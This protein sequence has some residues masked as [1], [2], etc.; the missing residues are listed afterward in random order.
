[1]TDFHRQQE[2]KLTDAAG[3]KHSHYFSEKVS[4]DYLPGESGSQGQPGVGTEVLHHSKQEG[5]SEITTTNTPLS[6]EPQHYTEAAKLIDQCH[7]DARREAEEFA[8]RQQQEQQ[9]L[10]EKE[11]ELSKL[12]SEAQ[13]RVAELE[14][15]VEK[16]RK[17]ELKD[18]RKLEEQENK[19]MKLAQ[20]LANKQQLARE[21]EEAKRNLAQMRQIQASQLAEQIAAKKERLRA[22]AE[23]RANQLAAEEEAAKIRAAE[24]A[25]HQAQNVETIK[26]R[27]QEL[28]INETVAKKNAEELAKRQETEQRE[29]DE[30]NDRLEKL[31]AEARMSEQLHD[32][33]A[34]E[35]AELE[36]RAWELA[37]AEERERERAQDLRQAQGMNEAAILNQQ[38]VISENEARLRDADFLAK[39]QVEERKQVEIT[40]KQCIQNEQEAL[41]KARKLAADLESK[42]K[43]NQEE[44]AG[45]TAEEQEARRRMFDLAQ[46]QNVQAAKVGQEPAILDV[47][48]HSR[49]EVGQQQPEL[50]NAATH[51]EG[52]EVR[53]EDN[54]EPRGLVGKITD[55]I[56]SIF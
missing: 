35:R 27:K 3:N 31:A 32:K 12:D 41:E 54:E 15:V 11:K 22:L 18:Q 49:Y 40:S 24:L 42:R 38:Q 43:A 55:G 37:A 26:I 8:K 48:Q 19:T 34:Q 6:Q 29:L 23:Q 7:A 10:S 44:L 1:M 47:Y 21:S 53:R 20:E 56:K 30:M 28:K 17:S 51:V 45:L 9:Y 39:K 36:R 46:R 13:K 52:Q 2:Q 16:E 25:N 5:L 50:I 14:K 33:H 4:S